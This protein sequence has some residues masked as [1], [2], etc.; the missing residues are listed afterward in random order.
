MGY[1]AYYT[2]LEAMQEAGSIDPAD[3][4]AALPGVTYTGVS[5]D[6]AFDDT[7]DA[8]RNAAFIK[9][10]NTETGEWDFVALQTIA[11]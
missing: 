9:K 8:I 10:A 5:G 7:G 2:A 11:E 1:D 6:I 3:I 4:M